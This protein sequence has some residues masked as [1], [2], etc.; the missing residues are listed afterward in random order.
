MRVTD[1]HKPVIVKEY[2]LLW[3][4]LQSPANS[5]NSCF[6]VTVMFGSEVWVYKYIMW[7]YLSGKEKWFIQ[8]DMKHTVWSHTPSKLVHPYHANNDDHIM[9][10]PLLDSWS[11]WWNQVLLEG[12]FKPF[13]HSSLETSTQHQNTLV[14]CYFHPESAATAVFRHTLLAKI[15]LQEILTAFIFKRICHF[16]IA[17]IGPLNYMKCHTN[18]W[19]WH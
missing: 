15:Q 4:K 13:L 1:S 3:Q 6:S 19:I 17:L 9:T 8:S 12:S 2:Y 11:K 10:W 18:S 5:T 7:Q 16:L 14:Q